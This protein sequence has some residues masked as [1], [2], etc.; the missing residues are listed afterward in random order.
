MKW[1]PLQ[2]QFQIPSDACMWYIFSEPTMPPPEK[3][4]MTASMS[5]TWWSRSPGP[6]K[7]RRHRRKS[8]R[9]RRRSQMRL[10]LNM[11]PQNLYTYIHIDFLPSKYIEYPSIDLLYIYIRDFLYI[12]FTF[13]YPCL[14]ARRRSP[15]SVMVLFQTWAA[16]R[17]GWLLMPLRQPMPRA[18]L[19]TNRVRLVYDFLG[20]VLYCSQSQGDLVL[21]ASYM[22][23]LYISIESDIYIYVHIQSQ[24][25]IVDVHAR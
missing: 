10:Q 4:C 15:W 20:Y 24:L 25:K 17:K 8:D 5:T 6:V 19:R 9:G 3:T 12:Y 7:R 18:S 1:K 11:F 2:T 16:C 23:V 21:Y 22:H 14:T 13:K